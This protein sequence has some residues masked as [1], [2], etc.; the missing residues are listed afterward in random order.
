MKSHATDGMFYT[1]KSSLKF[2]FSKRYLS[3]SAWSITA[4]LLFLFLWYAELLLYAYRQ[5]VGQGKILW[6]AESIDEVLK[7]DLTNDSLKAKLEFVLDVKEF[8][9]QELGLTKTESFTSL[10]D[11]KGQPLLWNVT[12][13]E[14]YALKAYEWNFPIVGRVGYKGFFEE[15]LA[16]D[17]AKKLALMSYDTSIYTVSAWSTLGYF[18]DPI[19]SEFLKRSKGEVAELIIH[20]LTHA[21]VYY[22][23]SVEFNENL[24]TFIGE[25]GA[26]L[27]LKSRYGEESADYQG[28]MEALY[29]ANLFLEFM[30]KAANF[31]DTNYRQMA[32]QKMALT[33]REVRKQTLLKQIKIAH[34]TLKYRTDVYRNYV[35]MEELNNTFFMNYLRYNNTQGYLHEI[36]E[37]QCQNSLTSFVRYIISDEAKQ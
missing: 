20:E 2:S 24:A 30:L 6:G 14:K 26:A 34:D 10:Y 17:E 33:H 28:Y 27:Y 8:A 22:A 31:M 18:N 23:D 4:F 15:K 21:T 13:A 16:K 37:T 12:G 7:Q 32:A 9:E 1:D 5:G 19:L 3:F 25:K 35:A 36:Y 11:Q 29:D